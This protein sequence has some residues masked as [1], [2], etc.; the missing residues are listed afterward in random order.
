MKYFAAIVIFMLCF[1]SSHV[2]AGEK[3]Y[4]ISTSY[5]TLFST[6]DQAGMLDR[7]VNEAFRRIGLKSKVVFT[8]NERSLI[9]VNEGMFDAEINRVAGMEKKFPHL[10]QVPE[11]NM[12]MHFVAFATKD[13]PISDWE[14]LRPYKIGL[15]KGWKILEQNTH[16][17]PHVKRLMSA[18]QL[19]LML[20]KE[21]LDVALFSKM[22]GYEWIKKL[23]CNRIKHLE[24]PLASKDMFLY[25]HKDNKELAK[26]L[27]KALREM[28]RDGTYDRIVQETTGFLLDKNRK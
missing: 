17:F 8:P 3:I 11:P 14:S 9:S 2:C 19:F 23:D 1:V 5:K 22:L 21:R 18:N 26:P 13:I 15:E 27:A 12:T 4:R 25:L 24:P 20:D 7:I 6:P 28:K 16:N 10:I